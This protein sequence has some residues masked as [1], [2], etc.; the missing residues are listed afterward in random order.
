MNDFPKIITERLI[1]SQL[2]TNDVPLLL[3]YMK[4]K[5]ISDMTSNIPYPYTED[6]AK[7]WFKISEEAYLSHNGIVFAIRNLD[8]QFMGG[9]GLHKNE[10]NEAEIGYWIGKPFWNQG[11]ITE[12]SVKILEFGFN[13]LGYQKIFGRVF[14]HNPASAK[15]LEKIGMQKEALLKNHYQKNDQFLDAIVYSKTKD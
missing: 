7:F 10:N 1:L 6:S 12:A 9:I 13:N 14:P 3:E 15:V 8:E 11:F 5:E 4:D 2:N